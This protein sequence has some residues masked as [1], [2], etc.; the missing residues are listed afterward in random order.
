MYLEACSAR[1]IRLAEHL[2]AC[3]PFTTRLQLADLNSDSGTV[4]QELLLI[5]SAA[6]LLQAGMLI[7]NFKNHSGCKELGQHYPFCTR[8]TQPFWCM[9]ITTCVL[10]Q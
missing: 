2:G 7:I 8:K 3:L 4:V 1:I 5:E 9:G 6:C 10:Q